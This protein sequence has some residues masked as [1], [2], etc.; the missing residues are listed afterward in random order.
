MDWKSWKAVMELDGLQPDYLAQFDGEIWTKWKDAVYPTIHEGAYVVFGHGADTEPQSSLWMAYLSEAMGDHFHEGMKI[1][2]YGCGGA[3][4]ANF[5]SGRLRDFTYYGVE[6]RNT[7]VGNWEPRNAIEIAKE[8][9]GHDSRVRLGYVGTAL[10]AEAISNANVALL[11]SIFTH[12]KIEESLKILDKLLPILERGAI[13]FTV[14][15]DS[16]YHWDSSGAHGVEECYTAVYNT[17]DQYDSYFKSKNIAG[18]VVG[19]IKLGSGYR[20]DIYR[21]E[22]IPGRS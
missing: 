12:L 2:D 14:I 7:Q 8:K 1:L 20:Q 10:E 16:K 4:Y 22:K 19:W 21:V 13:V 3:R 5:L 6:P 17:P 9:L 11:G 18:R 15:F